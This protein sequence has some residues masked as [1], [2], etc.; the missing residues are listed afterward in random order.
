MKAVD[1]FEKTLTPREER[2]IKMRFGIGDGSE[3]TLEEPHL[4]NSH[5]TRSTTGRSGPCC[6]PKRS[7]RKRP[8][9][10]IG[11]FIRVRLQSDKRVSSI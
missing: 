2:V 5:S 1:K 10:P 4:G 9:I 11:G 8:A 6:R 3:H 7:G